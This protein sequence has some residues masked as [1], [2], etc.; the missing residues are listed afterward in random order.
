MGRWTCFEVQVSLIGTLLIDC[1]AV[2]ILLLESEKG[3]Q[4]I[5]SD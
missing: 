5:K 3:L 4:G 1:T 2:S